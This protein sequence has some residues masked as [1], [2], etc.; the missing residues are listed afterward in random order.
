MAVLKG[1][2][3]GVEGG[4][5]V[6]EERIVGILL[7]HMVQE[8]YAEHELFCM[9]VAEVVV[10]FCEFYESGEV[11]VAA[12]VEAHHV[13]DFAV[14]YFSHVEVIGT[15]GF[16]AVAVHSVLNFCYAPLKHCNGGAGSRP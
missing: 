11:V 5:E 12:E 4:S 10:L 2:L 13:L 7:E 14:D 8:A 15:F 1:V 3:E 9:L 6:G 16:V